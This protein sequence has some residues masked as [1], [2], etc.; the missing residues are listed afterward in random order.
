MYISAGH[1]NLPDRSKSGLTFFTFYPIN[2]QKKFNKKSLF[3]KN[4]LDFSLKV[5]P[6]VRKTSS[7][8]TVKIL[9]VSGPDV[10][11]GR[12][13]L[14]YDHNWV[15]SEV[16]LIFVSHFVGPT[17]PT[18]CPCFPKE[19]S[20]VADSK[21]SAY[22]F[23]DK[24]C[25]SWSLRNCDK[26]HFDGKKQKSNFS[27]RSFWYVEDWCNIFQE[28]GTQFCLKFCPVFTCT[29]YINIHWKQAL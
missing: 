5:L 27:S 23:C 8:R 20:F 11:S 3:E 22:N 19:K 10:M 16:I 14:E 7:F 12:A 2:K 6:P 24:S 4:L 29:I 9:K 25:S 28:I 17:S 21:F 1:P 13:L 26:N 18:R 15:E